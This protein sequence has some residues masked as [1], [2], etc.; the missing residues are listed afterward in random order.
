MT[1]LSAELIRGELR[2]KPVTRRNRNHTPVE[3]RVAKILGIWLDAQP[4]PRGEI[5]S[6]EAGFRLRRNPDS[7]VGVNVAY[8]SA[9][10]FARAR[11]SAFYEGAPVLA[12]EILSP[13]DEQGETDD[14]IELY[15]ETGV[16]IVWIINPRFR[17]VA[18]Y[19]PDAPPAMFNATEEM[20]AE[21]HLPG[22]R[23]AVAKLFPA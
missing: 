15:L 2:Q 22:F 12:V 3:A 8:V 23:V 10:I 18:V 14:K 4:E 17:T 7:G 21:P 20:T 1:G 13:S 11:D 6:G 16:A 5:V 19:R 9:E